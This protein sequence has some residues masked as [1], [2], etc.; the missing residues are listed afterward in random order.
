MKNYLFF[1]L[2]LVYAFAKAQTALH[3]YGNLKIHPTGQIGF[4]TDVINDGI[5]NDN[6]GLA[7]FYN[8][9]R[10]LTFSGTNQ[11]NFENVELEVDDDLSLLTS[12]G[13]TGELDFISGRFITPRINPIIR[14]KFLN[15]NFYFNSNDNKHVDG[16]NEFSGSIDFTFPIGDEFE[17]KPLG[18]SNYTD[19]QFVAAYFKEDPN[20]PTTFVSGFNTSAFEPS[21]D[22][23]STTEFWYLDS[24]GTADV[25]LHWTLSSNVS[26]L[27][28]NLSQLR[29]AAWNATTNKW[30]NLGNDSFTGTVNEGTITTKI[31][32]TQEYTI[33]TL[34]SILENGNDIL[35]YNGIT[36]DGDGINDTLII[37]GLEDIPDNELIIY[38]RWG[39]AVYQKENYDNSFSGISEGRVTTSQDEKLPEGTYFYVLKIG[40]KENLAGYIYINR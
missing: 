23:V 12:I 32:A 14:L 19:K 39:V 6:D 25:T 5:S 17:L 29:I 16:F 13:I 36:P 37:R 7:G 18:I 8:D 20:T 9:N 1:T 22:I 40:N 30:D 24:T 4:H 31:N 2:L 3:N 26:S 27:V 10:M 38:N 28:N 34:A 33:Y 15:N 11:M 35:V 21:L